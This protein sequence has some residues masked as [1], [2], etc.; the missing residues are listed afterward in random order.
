MGHLNF[1]ATFSNPGRTSETN[2]DCVQSDF[3]FNENLKE[4]VYPE[5]PSPECGAT[6]FSEVQW[7]HFT[8][9]ASDPIATD[10][11]TRYLSLNHY[12]SRLDLDGDQYFG[13][14]GEYS[15]LVNRISKDLARFW[16]MEG[17]VEVRGQHNETLND[18]EEIV[19][20]LSRMIF[21]DVSLEDLYRIAD[22]MLLL[23][24]QS[25]VLPESPIFSSE[26][27]SAPGGLIVIGD[28]LIQMFVE[29]GI[30][31]T[32]AWTGILTHEWIHQIQ[33][34]N[35]N[36]WYPAGSFE[37][38]AEETR[39]IELEAD[40]FSAYYMT[41]KRGATLNW[42]RTTEFLKLFF[43]AGDCS[44]DFELHHGTPKQRMQATMAGHDLAASAQKK[45]KILS[46]EEVHD[47]F[48]SSLAQIL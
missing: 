29:A 23:N 21:D 37:T 22:E 9:L 43:Q 7:K 44:F 31:P 40:F 20:L 3:L 16:D 48:L 11:F 45:G 26:G 33:I 25:P 34:E 38:P 18:R 5:T 4:L 46:A 24:Q 6:A 39:Q 28:G 12:A 19:K 8:Q 14:D 2:K 30:E 10:N 17:E 13:P 47:H 41:H 42:K 35:Y 36:S 1:T 15:S 27:Y 32:I